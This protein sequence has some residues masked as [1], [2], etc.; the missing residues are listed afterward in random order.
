MLRQFLLAS[1]LILAPIAT[2]AQSQPTDS[3]TLQAL[4]S[5]V[6]QLRQQLLTSTTSMQRSQ[7]LL[8]R[9]DLQELAVQRA[10]QRRDEAQDKLTELQ[11]ERK[12]NEAIIKQASGQSEGTDQD[13]TVSVGGNATVNATESQAL[14]FIVP[15]IKARLESIDEEEQ[16]VQ[17]KL[18]EAEEQLRIEQS[19]LTD[20][21]DQLDRL[22]RSLSDST[23]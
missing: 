9:L 23:H 2:Q 22:D 7:I 14:T 17:T 13:T 3:Q 6:R 18:N 5:E 21:Q 11:K 4:L 1:T 16:Q 15:S 10:T 19:K 20:L 8:H 12:E